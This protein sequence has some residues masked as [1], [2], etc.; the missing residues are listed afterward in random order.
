MIDAKVD[1]SKEFWR[2]Y[3]ENF[4]N[5]Y[6]DKDGD[7]IL[8]IME[9]GKSKDI[10]AGERQIREMYGQKYGIQFGLVGGKLGGRRK[11]EIRIPE[12][13]AFREYFEGDLAEIKRRIREIGG[14]YDTEK[15]QKVINCYFSVASETEEEIWPEREY[16]KIF[17]MYMKFKEIILD[18]YLGRK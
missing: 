17:E 9:P 5:E 4:Q 8:G 1:G 10:F 15:S 14:I 16:P 13:E 3:W 2:R 11:V 12:V 18:Y 6:S 7:G